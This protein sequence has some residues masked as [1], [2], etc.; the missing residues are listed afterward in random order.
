MVRFFFWLV[1]LRSELTVVMWGED[2]GILLGVE[3][4]NY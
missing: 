4:G 2:I 3:W 1:S